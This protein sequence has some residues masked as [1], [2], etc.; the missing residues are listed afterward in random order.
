[1]TGVYLLGTNPA[2]RDRLSRW[3]VTS[4][5]WACHC[6]SSVELECNWLERACA[7]SAS[8]PTGKGGPAEARDHPERALA[9]FQELD[10]P[11]G[12]AAT[13]RARGEFGGPISETVRVFAK[14]RL[15]TIR[16]G[17][18]ASALAWP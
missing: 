18:M 15:D 6:L 4:K 5:A 7:G 10:H 13:L 17:L 11:R 2:E 8:W 16:H 1:M 3:P 9:L 12:V 14:L